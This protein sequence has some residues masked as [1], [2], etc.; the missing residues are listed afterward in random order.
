MIPIDEL[1]FFR[2]VG[3]NHQPDILQ[4]P[5]PSARDCFSCR[6]GPERKDAAARSV[7]NLGS[8]NLGFISLDLIG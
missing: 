3:L 2:R 4:A 6:V 8:R 7:R 1:I 5:L